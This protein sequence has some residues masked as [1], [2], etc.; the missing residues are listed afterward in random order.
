MENIWFWITS[1]LA[2]IFLLKYLGTLLANKD[3]QKDKELLA[4][5]NNVLNKELDA[6]TKELENI[7]QNICNYNENSLVQKK[8]L[9]QLQV[10]QNKLDHKS[11]DPEEPG[12]PESDLVITHE[13]QQAADAVASGKKCIFVHGGAGTGKSTFIKWMIRQGKIHVCLAPT[14]IAALNIGGQTLHKFFH[15][16]RYDVFTKD[17][18]DY[19]LPHESA[20]VLQSKPVIC[21][22]EISMVRSDMIDLIDR[23]LRVF[24]G[25]MEPFGGCQMVFVGDLYQLPPIVKKQNAK[26]FDSSHPDFD[27]QH[28]WYSPFFYDAE[29]FM[30]N[31]DR[32]EVALTAP[33][34]QAAGSEF[35]K[36]L[37]DIRIYDNIMASAGYINRCCTY[38]ADPPSGAVIITGTN[39]SADNYNSVRLDAINS[40]LHIYKA[41][42]DGVFC[43]MNE[44]DL[45]NS[46]KIELKVGA[47][48]MFLYNDPE[49]RFV[50]G[51]TGIVTLL[52]TEGAEVRL[53][54]GQSVRADLHT[55]ESYKTVWNKEKHIFEYV[56]DG[57]YT[58]VPLTLAYAITVHK[59]QGKTLD[60]IYIDLVPWESG[61]MYVALSRVRDVQDIALKK[62][63]T[64]GDFKVCHELQ[65]RCPWL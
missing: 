14:G 64:V 49:R 43:E 8:I 6:V 42:Y 13:F 20:A 18:C 58:Q 19:N 24:F 33:F 32:V 56:I 54:N 48:V 15:L 9:A 23:I 2:V 4:L 57:H 52:D 31:F 44:A 40:P 5:Q 12:D 38:A 3:L 11:I 63:V 53:K 37:N 29:V 47:F 36:V 1:G 41:V 22:D 25:S 27:I 26:F 50:N 28:G 65:R 45:P 16:P 34:R 21:I 39:A 60:S 55:W 35:V 59:S 30:Q 10:I 46:P 17:Y 7:K 61:Q 62:S 51:T